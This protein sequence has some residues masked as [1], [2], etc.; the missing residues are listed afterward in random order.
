MVSARRKLSKMAKPQSYTHDLADL[1]CGG[2]MYCLPDSIAYLRTVVRLV[3]RGTRQPRTLCHSRSTSLPEG[4][5]SMTLHLIPAV[6][7][8]RPLCT[9]SLNFLVATLPQARL[10]GL[11]KC[12]E[13]CMATNL[14]LMLSNKMNMNLGSPPTSRHLCSSATWSLRVLLA[15][16]RIQG[17]G[18]EG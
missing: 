8:A 13:P 18:G 15:R 9:L 6:D 3:C 11:Q 4:S 16:E 10:V 7:L 1:G 12:G 14:V 17:T 2:P 5:S